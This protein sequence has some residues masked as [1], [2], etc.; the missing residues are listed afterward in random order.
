MAGK[1]K[2]HPRGCREHCEA[3]ALIDTIMGSSPRMRGAPYRRPGTSAG[4]RIIPADAGSTRSQP[5][6]IVLPRDHPRGCGEHEHDDVLSSDLLGSSPRMRGALYRDNA[7]PGGNRIIPADAGSTG[8]AIG[9]VLMFADHPRGCG[10]HSASSVSARMRAGSSPRMRG[11]RAM[12][13]KAFGR[14]G[15]IPA[16]AGST[17]PVR[18]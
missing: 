15:I 17:W 5:L 10:E 9:A 13:C 1:F 7:F 14:P 3:A 18:L 2:D 12:Y 8:F 16:D 11:A 4:R 6:A